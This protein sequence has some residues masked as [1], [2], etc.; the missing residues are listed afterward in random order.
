MASIDKRPDGRY[1]ARWREYPGGPQKT[2]QF[3][4]KGDAQRFLDA[5]CGDLA[6][7]AYVDPAGGRR[8]FRDYAEQWRTAQVHRP[9]TAA[10]VETFLRLHAYPELGGRPIGSVR[11]SEIQAWVK[12][13]TGVLAPGAVEL[14]YRWVSAIFKAAVGD[15]LIASSPCIRIALP[16]RNDAEVVPLT[17]TEVQ[18]LAAAVPDRYRALIIFAAGMGLRQGECFGLTVDRV[19]FLR[20][21]RVDRQLISA[22]GGVP[23]FGPPKSKA[24]FRTVPMP[25]VVRSTLADHLARYRPRQF[26]LVFTNTWCNPL[27]RN[28]A[29]EMWHR[30]RREAGLPE[31]ATFHDLRHFYAS[32][33]IAKGSSVKTVQRCLGHQSAMETL[34]TYGHLWPDSEDETRNAVDDVLAG[35]TEVRG[36]LPT[37]LAASTK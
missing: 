9:T 8:L 11:R 6:H 4:R 28:S 22:R 18:A 33:L 19:D 20:R 26:A 1:R 13:L 32:L 17:V 27:R 31:W 3:A 16:K 29:G 7:G 34:D 30:A 5:V 10:S 14:V 37:A 35:V 21:V 15:R 12:A 2:R 25:D 23:E 24:G 36:L